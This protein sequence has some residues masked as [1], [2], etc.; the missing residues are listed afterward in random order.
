MEGKVTSLTQISQS[1]AQQ[2]RIV[3][4]MRKQGCFRG[5]SVVHLSMICTNA[6]KRF[7]SRY[8]VVYRE[9]A[10]AHTFYV[11]QQGVL[12]LSSEQASESVVLR[13]QAGG[14]LV[15]FGVEGVARG[16]P[17][18]HTVTCLSD[19]ELLHFSTFQQRLS[20][21]GAEALAQRA[22]AAFVEQE[23]KQMPLFFGLR[24]ELIFQIACM[25]QLREEG[26]AGTVIFE[27]GMPA[28]ALYIL[29]K[30]RV[31]L[32]QDGLVV[33]KL[34][35]GAAEDSHPFFGEKSILEGGLRATSAITRT[36]VRILVLPKIH[37][38]RVLKLM[39]S[40]TN[41]LNEFHGMRQ[42]RA[43]LARKAVA[44]AKQA[45]D[46]DR[47]AADVSGDV[48]MVRTARRENEQAATCVQ[49][50]WRGASAREAVKH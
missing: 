30:G 27:P 48:K 45:L 29:Y 40:L 43:E 28:D 32:E 20:D 12:Q 39:P 47:N 25:F 16:M 37:F 18:Q 23:L 5:T 17:R 15:C 35:G 34:Q 33:D 4:A 38:A 14:D 49:R 42:S 1:I 10:A 46:V 41:R 6:A 31:V 22:F 2:K 36:P 24:A 7:H 19:C 11:L 3:A 9:G 21:S 8:G 50:H 13:A 44:D 26:T